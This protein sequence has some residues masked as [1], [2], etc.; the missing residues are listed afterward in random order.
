MYYFGYYTSL[1]IYA[2]VALWSKAMQYSLCTNIDKRKSLRGLIWLT[3]FFDHII[4]SEALISH[5]AIADAFHPQIHAYVLYK[6][7]AIN[8]RL[9]HLSGGCWP[10]SG[11]SFLLSVFGRSLLRVII[12][13]LARR[14]DRPADSDVR[15]MGSSSGLPI[16]A[17]R[18]RMP[19]QWLWSL[20]NS[21]DCKNKNALQLWLL[22]F[23]D[24][25]ATIEWKSVH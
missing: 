19:P 5:T 17:L 2:L 20:L 16:R 6:R 3:Q 11:T 23:I 21:Y 4:D 14:R 1:G 13:L 9:W 8:T 15:T 10:Q 24:K 12:S 22:L 25:Q 7:S 18:S